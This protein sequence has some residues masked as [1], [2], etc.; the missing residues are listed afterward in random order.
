MRAEESS[1]AFAVPIDFLHLADCSPK[2]AEL[3]LHDAKSLLEELELAII[4]EQEAALERHRGDPI[5]TVKEFVR[6]RL[7]GPIAGDRSEDR[8]VCSFKFKL[9]P[10]IKMDKC[11]SHVKHLTF[12]GREEVNR[13][14]KTC[15]VR[16]M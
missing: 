1:A 10:C 16:A 2:A 15:Y 3:L 8:H 5:L 13:N 9:F 6:P 11:L 14:D 7:A 4:R 12:C